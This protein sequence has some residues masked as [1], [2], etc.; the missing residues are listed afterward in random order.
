MNRWRFYRL[1]GHM[2]W[3]VFLVASFILA[4][5]MIAAQIFGCAGA[6]TAAD[7]VKAEVCWEKINGAVQS[8]PTCPQA[9]DAIAY[10]LK[11]DPSCAVTTHALILVCEDGGTHD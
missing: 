11:R 2:L 10:V 5:V 3:A 1:Y 4:V 8:A 9:V 6:E 7:T